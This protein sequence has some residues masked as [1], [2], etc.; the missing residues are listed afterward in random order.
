ML[1]V[2]IPWRAQPSRQAAFDATV[3]WYRSNFS[4]VE[5]RTI[6][7]AD[8][9]FNL[10]QCRN[11][12]I[13]SIDNP[14][15]VVV[16]NDADTI[17]QIGPLREAIA[18]AATSGVVHLPYT[19]YHWLGAAGT[20]QYAAGTD[21]ADCEFELVRGACS[22]VYVTTPAT[23]WSHGGQDERFRGWGFEDAAWNVAH[24]TL[25]G[26]EPRRHVGSV[27]AL[28]HEPQAREGDQYDA[29]AA[30]M[31]QY[32]AAGL[33]ADAMREFLFPA[34]GDTA[35]RHI[36][37]IGDIGVADDIVHIGDEA[38][39]H[40]MITQLRQRGV[41]TIIGISS[42]PFESAERYGISSIDRIGFFTDPE[43]SREPA[44]ERM[45][46]VIRTA[47]GE[48]DLLAADD[49]AH[50]VIDAIRESDGV[51]VAG[52]GNIASTWPTHIFERA[53]LTQIARIFDKPVVISG[54]TI[55]PFLTPEDET[56]VAAMLNSATLVGLREQPSYDYS[57][58]LGV[59]PALINKTVD[60]ASFLGIDAPV[61]TTLPDVPYCVV[62][63]AAH[64]GGI[65]P[66]LFDQRMA[67]LLDGIATDFN[68]D[69]RFFAHF[70]STRSDVAHGDTVV[71]NRIMARMTSDRAAI[72][73]T[74]DSVTAAQLARGAALS[75][76]SRYHPAVFAV[77]AGVPTIGIAVDDYTTTKLTGALGNYGQN[78]V[79][80][81][82]DLIAGA[83]PALA[84]R[85]WNDRAS[86]RENGAATAAA[87]RV[88][89]ATWWDRIARTLGASVGA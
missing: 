88:G 52:G 25:L 75:V 66:E 42:H 7:S 33:D 38:M 24:T 65:D 62:T 61:S 6:D 21:L 8:E 49:P 87:H 53:T 55:G 86:I 18:A 5:I 34:P 2:V 81:I 3:Q 32:R 58:R 73:A 50:A 23:W 46:L 17:P 74:T 63:M 69:I 59:S 40:E 71:H 79:L 76:S 37:A 13:R 43:R 57:A 78:A 67:E 27:F 85:V 30:L 47:K 45:R 80:P 39:F 35:P 19:E 36:V 41:T 83:G 51:A 29:N 9:V 15:E 82:A 54:Q 1:T 89:S 44:E 77:S 10:A 11:I 22:G 20:A 48:R 72:F 31:D 70:G 28:H 12:G 56:I 26:E 16:I 14:G 84:Q 4:E 68:L 64:L 60:D